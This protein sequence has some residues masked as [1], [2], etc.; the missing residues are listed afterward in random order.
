M[1]HLRKEHRKEMLIIVQSI[2]DGVR[3]DEVEGVS[4]GLE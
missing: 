3:N 4:R 2:P 1:K